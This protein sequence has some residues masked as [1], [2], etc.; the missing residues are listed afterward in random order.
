MQHFPTKPKDQNAS[1]V[2]VCINS[3]TTN[4]LGSAA[5][6]IVNPILLGWKPRWV[7]HMT[8]IFTFSRS[9]GLITNGI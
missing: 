3:N 8:L 6:V 7:N 1:S 9:I 5:K 4:N 2:M